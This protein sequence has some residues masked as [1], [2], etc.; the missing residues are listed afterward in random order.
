MKTDQNEQK[1]LNHPFYQDANQYR[2]KV[3][4]GQIVKGSKKYPEPFTTASWSNEE[5]IEHA[6][7]ENVDQTHYIY[8]ALERM[9]ALQNDL[10]E[11]EEENIWLNKQLLQAKE[12]IRDLKIKDRVSK[13]LELE[14]HNLRL[15]QEI[16]RLKDDK[17]LYQKLFVKCQLKE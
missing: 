16:G 9:Q 17:D 15:A 14:E 13:C 3:R 11:L 6:M 12:T 4:V 1:H 7:Q 5:I 2:E 10:R 8:A